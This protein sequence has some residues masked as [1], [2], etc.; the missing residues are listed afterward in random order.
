MKNKKI[1]LKILTAA[2][3][4]CVVLFAFASCGDDNNDTQENGG[5]N[6]G[7]DN[8]ENAGPAPVSFLQKA[9]TGD[10]NNYGGSVGYEILVNADIQVTAVGRPVS[11]E[12]NQA[13]TIYIWEVSSETL[14]ASAEVTP[15]SPVDSLGFKTAQLGSPI[16]LK[17]G[18]SYRIVSAEFDGGD[19]WYDVGVEDSVG[20]PDLQPTASATITTPV[21]TDGEAHGSFPGNVHNP[22]GI[23]G[24]VGVTFYYIPVSE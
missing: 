10:R 1:L 15:D 14:L 7:N 20:I 24:Y 4:L 17:A 16:I 3:M 19:M 22:G 2:I 6:A 12:M 5:G 21:F 13:H 8:D 9:E 18:E 11:G 23:R